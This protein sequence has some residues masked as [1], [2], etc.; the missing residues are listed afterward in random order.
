MPQFKPDA[1]ALLESSFQASP[2]FRSHKSLPHRSEDFHTF[3]PGAEPL[4]HRDSYEDDE[5]LSHMSSQDHPRLASPGILNGA[6]TGLPPTPPSNSHDEEPSGSFSAPPHADSVVSSLMSKKSSLSTPVNQRSPPTPDPSPPRTTESM[7]LPVR[8]NVFAYPSSRAESFKTAREDQFSTDGSDSRASTPLA[9]RLSTVNEERGL[10]LA[11]EREDDDITPTNRA[12]DPFS[13]MGGDGFVTAVEERKDPLEEVIPDREWDTNLMRNV[14]IRRKRNPKPSP[15]KHLDSMDTATSATGSPRRSSSLRE[16]I[17]ASK[18][19]PHTPSMETFA[20]SIGWPTEA[21]N[22]VI[23]SPRDIENKRMSGSSMTS[24]VVEAMVIVTPPQRRRTLRHSGRNL[25]YRKDG[26]SSTEQIST[27]SSN[28]N[29]LN[30]EDIPLHRLIHKRVSINDRRQ[31]ISSE[32]DSL[33]MDRTGSPHSLRQRALDNAAFTLAHQ[34]SVREVLQP[35]AEILS[36]SNSESRPYDASRSYHK[37]I[38]SAPETTRK[39]EYTS[40][41]PRTFLELSPPHSPVEP[42]N[43]PLLLPRLARVSPS[44]ISKPEH[45]SI[46]SPKK[47]TK[48]RSM[49]IPRGS[50]NVNKSLPELPIQS[51]DQIA[52][53]EDASPHPDSRV[54]QVPHSTPYHDA[55]SE[56]PEEEA[57]P[58]V[59]VVESEQEQHPPQMRQDSSMD[60]VPVLP[61][62]SNSSRGRSEERRRSSVSQERTS[63]SRDTVLRP[64]LD[65]IPTE[66]LPRRSYEWRSLHADDHRRVSFDRSTIR[67]DEHAMARHLFAQTTPFSQFSDTLEVSEATTVSI[68]PHNNHSLLVVQQVARSSTLPLEQ[69]EVPEDPHIPSE[70]KASEMASSAL[71]L[72]VQ[73][74]EPPQLTHPTVT[75]EPSTPPMQLSLPVPGAVDSPLK[76]PRAA[77]EPPVFKVIPPTPADELDRQL[78]PGPH[79]PPGPPKRSDSH[80]Q[81]RLSLVQRAR[82]YSDN[83]ISP[84]LAR[85]S[86]TRGRHVSDSHTHPRV[87]TVSDEDNALHPFWRPRGFWDGFEDSDSESDDDILPEGGDTSDI[88]DEPEPEPSPR[89]L[90]VLGR[91]LSRGTKGFLIG[92]SLGVERSGTNR[93]RPQIKLPSSSGRSSSRQEVPKLMV[94]RPTLPIRTGSPRIE[95]RGSKGSM[96]SL[97]SIERRERRNNRREQWKQ[98]RRI[99]GVRLQVQY[100][101]LSGVKERFKERKAEKRRQEIRKSIG[102]RYYVEDGPNAV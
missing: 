27:T 80:P 5:T 48:K 79:A 51:T 29:S 63:T 53:A 96:H 4:K 18:S 46:E 2:N 54:E 87:P 22:K 78:A 19:S 42:A 65:R 43:E 92:N 47:R 20:R 86:S 64:S 26:G 50:I 70:S 98:G 16:R 66:E 81:R 61:R 57:M 39:M 91:R 97:A 25:A 8:P 36:R 99:P 68:Y 24:T 30:S 56:W 69:R 28:R 77:P 76:N 75:I 17:E 90:G 13:E 3:F 67:S 71:L 40:R 35:A 88:E 95:K 59:H 72:D 9:D 41:G 89:K 83:L 23:D 82:R 37:R 15:Q 58:Q 100:I 32:S 44:P 31:R 21:S 7:T 49:S 60:A 10:G 6:D 93:R 94:Q 11:F 55:L 52:P 62:G 1:Y 73:E 34:D 33:G 85:A 102:S 14:T 101:G 12:R 74:N 45:A 84:F 38:S